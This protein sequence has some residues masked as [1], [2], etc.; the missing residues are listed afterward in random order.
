MI[1]DRRDM[2]LGVAVGGEKVDRSVTRDLQGR[3]G[4]RGSTGRRVGDGHDGPVGFWPAG[5]QGERRIF[6]IADRKEHQERIA[7]LRG[8]DD[9]R[10]V[11]R[12]RSSAARAGRRRN[13]QQA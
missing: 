7:L 6:E 10:Q 8:P 2:D 13:V 9:G 4:Q 3:A 1:P 12:W 5:R 11:R